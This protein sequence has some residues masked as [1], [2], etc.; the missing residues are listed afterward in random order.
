MRKVLEEERVESRKRADCVL[1]E[2]IRFIAIQKPWKIIAAIAKQEK[3]GT[4]GTIR[5]TRRATRSLTLRA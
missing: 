4:K 3:D 1:E 2:K 5:A